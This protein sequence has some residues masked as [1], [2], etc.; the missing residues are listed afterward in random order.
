MKRGLERVS[1]RPLLTLGYHRR[2]TVDAIIF[3]I[4][5]LGVVTPTLLYFLMIINII[6]N[7]YYIIIII[8]VYKIRRSLSCNIVPSLLIIFRRYF[9]DT[10]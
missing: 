5:R 6:I 1:S 8:I 9:G 10:L 7:Y 3:I 4:T 2:Q